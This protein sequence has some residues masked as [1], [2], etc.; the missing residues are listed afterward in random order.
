MKKNYNI[1]T[2]VSETNDV[3]QK[4]LKAYEKIK[5][6]PKNDILIFEIFHDV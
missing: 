1:T 6:L 5:K 4:I 2:Y 3:Y